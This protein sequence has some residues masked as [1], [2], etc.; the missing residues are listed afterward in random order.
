MNNIE[1]KYIF[2]VDDDEDDCLLF[3]DALKEVCD[4]TELR[5]ANDGIELMDILENK[6]P[7]TPD[8]IFLDLNMPKKNGFECLSEIRKDLK[9]KHIPVVI[10]STCGEEETINRLY[11]EGANC[12]IKK[13]GSFSKLKMAIQYILSIDWRQVPFKTFKENFYFQF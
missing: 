3:K 2:L 11:D 13:P 6:M 10:F 4:T 9:F 1:R 7:P 5:T 8:V 12:Y